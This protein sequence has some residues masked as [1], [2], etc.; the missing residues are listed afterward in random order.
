MEEQSFTFEVNEKKYTA[1]FRI[2]DDR[3]PKQLQV[4]E[5]SPTDYCPEQPYIFTINQESG[6]LNFA[7]KDS[8]A[9]EY[10]VP[11]SKAIIARCKEL[12]I[13]LFDGIHY[14]GHEHDNSI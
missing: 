1:K 2:I 6:D 13:S 9:T 12:G 7:L 5:I 8:K 11:V 10:G 4:Y 3:Y 14:A